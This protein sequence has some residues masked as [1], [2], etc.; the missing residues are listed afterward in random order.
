MDFL[1]LGFIKPMQPTTVFQASQVQDAFRFM[2]K[3]QH[4]GKIIVQMPAH[5]HALP[6]F[7]KVKKLVLRPDVYYLLI[8]GRGGFRK[9]ISSWIVEH[10]AK[11]LIFLSRSAGKSMK[12]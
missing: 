1:R 9:S 2:E 8:G 3:G 7:S 5:A 6:S 12:D 4:I 11:H 10:G